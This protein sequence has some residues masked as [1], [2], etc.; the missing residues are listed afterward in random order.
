[1]RSRTFAVLAAGL[2][3]LLTLGGVASAAPSGS[4]GPAATASRTAPALE[5]VAYGPERIIEMLTARGYTELRFTDKS[6]PIYVV[7][8]CLGGDRLRVHLSRWGDIVHRKRVGECRKVPTLA[9]PEED[10]ATSDLRSAL[11]ARGFSRVRIIDPNPPRI[12]VEACRNGRK[13]RL[14]VNRFG[15]VRDRKIIGRCAEGSGSDDEDVTAGPGEE[16]VEDGSGPSTSDEDADGDPGASG[17]ET[18]EVVPS[19]K[20]GKLPGLFNTPGSKAQIRS[21]L[22]EQ[23]FTEIVFTGRQFFRYVIEACRGDTKYRMVLNRFGEVRKSSRIGTCE[24]AEEDFVKAPAP[25]RY[26]MSEI[27][28]KGRVQ[29]ELCQEYFDW[30]LYERTVL[31]D[32]ASARVRPDSYELLTDLAYV[33]SRCPETTIEISGHTDSDGSYAYNQEL[34]EQRAQAVL[35]F[36]ARRDVERDRLFAVGYGEQRPVASNRDPEGKAQN[37]RIEFTV[38]WE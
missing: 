18:V 3:M 10:L 32:V 15:D 9:V 19:G 31:F 37:R 36:L 16:V 5:R 14:V 28:R 6:L 22:T 27:R 34:S 29:P 4:L 24:V 8:G 38:R 13:L 35:G 30:L 21:V 11:V 12:V 26:S 25:R 33:A 1:M 20:P 7:E 23:G 2:G 17:D